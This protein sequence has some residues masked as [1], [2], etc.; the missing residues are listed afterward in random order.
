MLADI[1]DMEETSLFEVKM[2][3]GVTSLWELPVLLRWV[4][5]RTQAVVSV[6]GLRSSPVTQDETRTVHLTQASPTDPHCE[7]QVWDTETL[8]QTGEERL[9]EWCLN[10]VRDGELPQ[11]RQ[12]SQPA[13][14]GP[15]GRESSE[16]W[17]CRQEMKSKLLGPDTCS[18][19]WSLHL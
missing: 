12:R 19:G 10:S 17:E 2:A 4:K 8:Q 7:I 3:A 11:A 6:G 5:G 16:S 14:W 9:V 13:S 15:G 18:P 1:C